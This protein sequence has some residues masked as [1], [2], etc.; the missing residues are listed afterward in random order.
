MGVD[1]PGRGRAGPRL[2]ARLPAPQP[3]LAAGGPDDPG[4]H[5]VERHRSRPPLRSRPGPGRDH[6]PR[7]HP[8]RPAGTDRRRRPAGAAAGRRA[9]ARAAHA[10]R[11]RAGRGRAGPAPNPVAR[12]V[13][14]GARVRAPQH[15]AAHAH[16]RG[17][18][19]RRAQRGRPGGRP[20]RRHPGRPGGCGGLLGAGERARRAPQPS[21]RRVP[22]GVLRPG[23]G[24]ADPLSGRRERV[25]VRIGRSRHRPGARRSHGARH[26]HRRRPGRRPGRG[27][28]HLRGRAPRL[29]RH[30]P[31]RHGPGAD[32]RPAAGPQR[33]RGR[34]GP[35]RRAGRAVRDPAA[36]PIRRRRRAAGRPGRQRPAR[37][38]RRASTP[39]RRG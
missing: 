23:H 26:R 36:C 27:R 13:P 25:P 20:R 15:R 38:W 12:G 21:G 37:G 10:A 33:R 19:R 30:D 39:T 34:R 24:G 7:L 28:G 22:A 31:R 5:D 8:R 14:K 1:C 17:A 9:L 35:P 11:A 2:A 3:G 32:P 16:R 29:G 18:P 6:G 4:R